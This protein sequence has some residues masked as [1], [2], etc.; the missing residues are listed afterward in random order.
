MAGQNLVF[1]I[2][3]RGADKLAG[4]FRKAGSAAALTARN[5]RLCADA[6]QAQERAGKAAASGLQTAER[7]SAL[8]AVT[9][10][11]LD[12]EIEKTNR[13][14]VTQGVAAKAAGTGAY[15][16]R[17]GF[18]GLA[19]EVTGFGAAADAANSRGSRL[20]LVLAGI[21]LASG[22]AE[23]ALAG[24]VV[25][26]GGLAA[27]FAS[28]AA[29]LGAFGAV[30][31]ANLSAASGAADKASAAQT[32]Y[33]GAVAAANSKY[34]QAMDAATTKAQRQAAVTARQNALQ[35]AQAAKV[36]ATTAAYADLTP[37][38]VQ[39]SKSVGAMKDRWQQFT[40]GFAPM[41]NRILGKIQPVFGTVLGY[42]GKLATAGGTAI[43]AL[44]PHLTMALNS[45][46][47][48]D[49]IDLL[50]KNAGPAIVKI[51][52]AI[53]HI[54]VGIGG[55]LKAFMPVSQGMLT[56]LDK[57][58]AK[59]AQWGSTLSGHTGFASLMTTFREETP[60]AVAILRNLG[61][62]LGNVGKATFGL[63][64][65]SNSK[66]LLSAL[67]PLSGV[68]ASLSKN[69]D[70]VR[71]ALY[72]LVAVKIGQQFSWVTDAWKGI[73]K[74]AAAAEGATVA[75]T[76][77]AA[78]TRAWGIAMDALPWVALAAAVVAV[79]VLIIK[80]HRQ[81]W[82]FIQKVW[83]DVLAVIMGVWTWVKQHWPLLL[84]ILT[85]PVGL[86]ILWIVR[87][88]GEITTAVKTV[89]G[90]V[91]RAWNAVWNTL[92]A[93]FRIFVV[94]G[95]LGPLGLIVHGAAAAFGWVPGLG[96]RLKGAAKAF[97]TFRANVN[98]ALGGINGRTV[99]VSVAMTSST[100]PYPGGISGRKAAGG[101]ITGP[102]GPRSDRAGLYALS[103]E[104]WV[105][106]ADSAA[107]YGHAAMAAVNEGRAFIGYAGGGGVGV[108]ASAPGYK[109]VE[110]SLMASVTKLAK[111][112]AA[113]AAQLNPFAG[114]TGVP[115]GGKISGSAAAAQAFAR[116]ILWAYGWGMNQFPSLQALWNG[117]SGWNYLA[118]NAASGATG[119]PQSLPGSKM[120][121]AGADWRTNPA[122]QIRW[123]LGYIKSVY[124]SPANAYGRWLGRS[125]HWYDQ[126]GW[127]PPGLTLAYNGTGRPEPV[128]AAAGRGGNTYNITVNVPPTASKADTG[129]VIVEHIREY[130]RGSGPGWRR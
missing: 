2:S 72:A 47:F 62:V 83:H 50:A 23:P 39:L 120:A 127:L 117:E 9:E 100:N 115:S 75:E 88:F 82:A 69:T 16:A 14:L 11:E 54:A 33:T 93:A 95:I 129:R 128:G 65:F 53:G 123:G 111:A 105:I 101:R 74:F 126:G 87:H 67:L 64:T 38:Q 12:K 61:T 46:G 73:V 20:Q 112:F 122:T 109:T 49:F 118:Y 4:D 90:A 94:N 98:A 42:I 44:L 21:N 76:I 78:A 85:G 91:S 92:K 8:L 96:G 52:A 6:L 113:A 15:A 63:S 40:A 22:V 68:M 57:I 25:A 18:A 84:G 125:P 103:N 114:I 130:E 81:I 121:S 13:A 86:A 51:G 31:G 34:A 41:L 37:A 19:G 119:I 17:G 79:A 3:S 48:R 108:K 97:D 1:D 5:T 107:R 60:Q 26:A 36:R 43:E 27:G 24:L 55:I 99:K 106:R 80:Y 116:S 35:S 29:G 32:A 71:V 56:G 58:T 59:F 28:A 104:E 45:K 66:S 77:A 102:G 110:T 7:V 89:L 30:A 10:H 70:L 124:G